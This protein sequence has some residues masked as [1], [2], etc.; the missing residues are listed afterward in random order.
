MPNESCRNEILELVEQ[1]S[2]VRE[3]PARQPHA[4][5]SSIVNND[6]GEVVVSSLRPIFRRC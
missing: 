2:P 6:A 3:L 1:Y 5:S 4:Q